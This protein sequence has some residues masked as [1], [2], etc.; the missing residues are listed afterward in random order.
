MLPV[1]ETLPAQ[2]H[3]QQIQDFSE[4][5]NTRFFCSIFTYIKTIHLVTTIFNAS[6]TCRKWKALID[7]KSLWDI[8][9]AN[10]DIPIPDDLIY[11]HSRITTSRLVSQ[12]HNPSF[13]EIEIALSI[14]QNVMRFTS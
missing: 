12:A 9:V 13:Q 6:L 3:I 4:C 10:L 1:N 5:F 11:Y 2:F 8:I 14:L 7:G